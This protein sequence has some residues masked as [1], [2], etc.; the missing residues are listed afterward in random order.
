[1]AKKP[2]T[3]K[4]TKTRKFIA[5]W[6]RR[7]VPTAQVAAG[8][9]IKPGDY[10]AFAILGW[11]EKHAGAAIVGLQMVVIQEQPF[12]NK[13]ILTLGCPITPKTDLYVNALLQ[14][15]GWDG[16]V[17]PYKDHGWPE[18]TDDEAQV[19]AL[20]NQ[21]KLGCTLTFA[22]DPEKGMVPMIPVHIAKSKEPFPLAPFEEID[23]PPVHLEAFRA[24]IADPSPF[25]PEEKA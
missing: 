11:V 3:K 16:R 9:S 14:T 20:V 12:K 13:G 7:E 17:W 6:G 23:S 25:A 8:S 24:L 21:A 15:L 4:D 18:G 22:P 19:V 2:K 10:R 1:M 5:D